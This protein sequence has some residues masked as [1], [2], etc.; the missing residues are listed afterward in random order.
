MVAVEVI[1]AIWVVLLQGEIP[2]GQVAALL[3]QC[4][5]EGVRQH[6][7]E[8]LRQLEVC[9]TLPFLLSLTNICQRQRGRPTPRQRGLLCGA[10]TQ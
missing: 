7:E 10:K 3:C 1:Q 5:Q 4:H 2:N 8:V 9:P 6:G